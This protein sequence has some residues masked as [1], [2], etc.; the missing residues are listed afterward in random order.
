MVKE[1]ERRLLLTGV[2]NINST[3]DLVSMKQ[4]YVEMLSDKDSFRIR[5]IAGQ[6][7]V[8][9]LKSGIGVSRDEDEQCVDLGFADKLFER[10][11]HQIYKTK[12]KHDGWEIHVFGDVLAGVV[13]AEKEFDDPGK[14][15]SIPDWLQPFVIREVTHSLTSLH[16]ARLASDL[17]GTNSS[18]LM[19]LARQFV[20]IPVGVLTGGP[21]SGKSSIIEMLRSQYRNVHFVP[22]VASIVIGQLGIKPPFH[23]PVE[24]RRYQQLIYKVS[25]LFETTS[26]QHA[27]EQKKT[28]IVLDRGKPDN[29]VYLP[30]G[31]SE[32]EQLFGNSMMREFDQYN[33]VAHLSVPPK[34]I[35]VRIMA[36][37]PARSEDYYQAL[38]LDRK[39]GQVWGSNPCY[40]SASS[41]NWKTK[42]KQVTDALK[43]H[44][45]IT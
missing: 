3:V 4:G 14:P 2:P 36:N 27:V 13:L 43:T 12:I 32:F 23:D 26:I 10:S 11:H 45:I 34:K 33:V 29:A 6:E 30:G 18:P 42:V 31:V 44:G 7:A 19:H 39:I 8:L 9:G 41:K 22:E 20:P 15:F 1:H 38:E 21:G 28:G 35:Y 17:K 40:V 24:W 16:L 25:K 5:I 37:N